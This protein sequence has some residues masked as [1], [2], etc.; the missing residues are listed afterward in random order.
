MFILEKKKGM[1]QR[2]KILPQKVRKTQS[3]PRLN[4]KKEII[5]MRT[6]VIGN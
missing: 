2:L 4:R 6:N 3:K 5:K 1:N